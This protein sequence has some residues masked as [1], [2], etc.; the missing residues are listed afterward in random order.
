MREQSVDA[1]LRRR[2]FENEL[3][4]AVLLCNRVIVADHDRT[5]RIPFCEPGAK[6]R[7]VRSIRQSQHACRN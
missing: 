1:I 4:L 3:R 6:D 7:D 5:V 2:R